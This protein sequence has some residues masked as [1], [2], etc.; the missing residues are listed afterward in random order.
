MRYVWISLYL[1]LLLSACQVKETKPIIAVYKQDS[2]VSQAQFPFPQIP[3]MLNT[4]ED[5][6]AY[7]LTHYWEQLDFA[8][9]TLVNHRDVT[10][11]GFVNFI[12]LLAEENTSE[13]LIRES[14]KNWSSRFLPEVH[15]RKVL[16]QMADDYWYNPNSPFYNERLYGLY[17]ETLL[18]QLPQEDAMRFSYQ[19]KLELLKRNQVGK[20][21][22]DFQYELSDGTR[23]SLMATPVKGNRLLLL[24]YDPECESCHEVLL[25]MAADKALA[26]AVKAGQISVLAIYTEGNEDAWRKN[27]PDMPAGWIVGMDREVV[28]NEVL[29]DLKAMPSLYLLDGKTQVLLKDAPFEAIRQALSFK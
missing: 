21:A 7:L 9:T 10:E 25:Q 23:R 17:L 3:A 27:L 18:S 26:A 19:F 14:L 22:T 15:A 2:I 1:L 12:A 13:E 24:F 20:L 16:T 4:A 8:D 29:Y 5:R 28:K 11:Q 6:K